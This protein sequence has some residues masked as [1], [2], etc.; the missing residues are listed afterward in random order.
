[1]RFGGIGKVMLKPRI[2]RLV[3]G[4]SLAIAL[5][6]LGGCDQLRNAQTSS[7]S[8]SPTATVGSEI[9]QSPE[10][11]PTGTVPEPTTAP[12]TKPPSV[13]RSQPE[14]YW[15]TTAENK[16]A[17][18]PSPLTAGPGQKTEE[19]RLTAALDRLIKGPANADVTTTIPSETKVNSLKVK[20]DG[21]HVDLNKA[22]T[23]G[24]G[25]TAMQGRLGQVLYTA[26]SLDPNTPIWISVD[27]EPLKVLGGEG[28]IVSQPM[29]REEFDKNFSL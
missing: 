3:M 18:A 6:G 25:S 14:V 7:P 22:F 20:P 24:G 16:V 1:M 13:K 11:S 2:S 10:A 26:S 28:L 15:L 17:L 21:V 8:P 9:S 19:Q 12:A 23:S 4:T 27:G 29:T 5:I